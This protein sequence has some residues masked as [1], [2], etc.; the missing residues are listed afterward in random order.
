MIYTIHTFKLEPQNYD[1]FVHNNEEDI[2]PALERQGARVL[3]LWVVVIGGPERILLM[4]QYDSLA[5]WQEIQNWMSGVI[6]SQSTS[7]KLTSLIQDT[8]VIALRPLTQLQPEGSAPETDPGIYTL[9]RFEVERENIERLVEL[10]EKG[11]WPWVR[12]G[13][14][15][16]PVGQWLSIIAPETMVYMISRYNDLAHWEATRGYGPEPS[17]PEM[18]AIWEKGRT[19]LRERTALTRRTD[20]RILLPI[21]SRRP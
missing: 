2:W 10:S 11:W 6:R 20:V 17:D 7:S 14:G 13:Q 12:K 19:A 3:G 18:Q 21:S 16:R 15:I 8:E 5:H 1:K 4:T 9:R